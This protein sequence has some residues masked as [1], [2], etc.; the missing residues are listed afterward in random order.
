MNALV[1]VIQRNVV[2]LGYA[3]EGFD[4]SCRAYKSLVQGKEATG[5]P[6]LT[7]RQG[8]AAPVES[9]LSNLRALED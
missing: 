4:N 8:E 5:K 7:A 3:T 2:K 9:H 1:W 6:A